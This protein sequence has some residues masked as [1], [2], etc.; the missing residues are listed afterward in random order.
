MHPVMLEDSILE[1][2]EDLLQA[3]ILRFSID[4]L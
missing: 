2:L 3:C 1:M 4:P